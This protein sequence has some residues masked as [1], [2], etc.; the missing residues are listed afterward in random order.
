MCL[1]SIDF[2]LYIWK[3]MRYML[4]IKSKFSIAFQFLIDCQTEVV[5]KSALSSFASHVQ[6]ELYHNL[7]KEVMDK[8]A[9]NNANYEIQ[10][11]IW[12][13]FKTFNV[14]D[15]ILLANSTDPFQIL[16]KLNCHIYV[17]DFGISSIFNIEDLVDYKYFDFIPGNSL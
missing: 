13:L 7:H 5:H 6:V 17:I 9:Q 10:I 16:K 8:I 14:G 11:D 15:V 3:T 2:H 4:R 1:V 12:K